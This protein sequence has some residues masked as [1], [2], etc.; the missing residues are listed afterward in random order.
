MRYVI[1][2]RGNLVSHRNAHVSNI[3]IS[4]RCVDTHILQE[5]SLYFGSLVNCDQEKRSLLKVPDCKYF[6]FI[7]FKAL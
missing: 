6:H 5:R 3:F 4:E 2:Q 1:E 7:S